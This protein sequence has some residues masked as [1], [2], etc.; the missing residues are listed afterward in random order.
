MMNTRDGQSWQMT[1]N[2]TRASKQ[3]AA[4][5]KQAKTLLPAWPRGLMRTMKD[6]DCDV[7]VVRGNDGRNSQHKPCAN[8]RPLSMISNCRK[9][10]SSS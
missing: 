2:K 1:N 4:S 9:M 5:L 7:D 3:K 6:G 10:V 8:E